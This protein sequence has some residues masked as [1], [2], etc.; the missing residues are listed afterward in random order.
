MAW[1]PEVLVFFLAITPVVGCSVAPPEKPDDVCEIFDER[2]KWYRQALAA[3]K[4]WDMPVAVGLA[5][6]H[7]ESSY[8]SD[9][10]PP[11][12]RFLWVFPGRRPSSAYGYAQATDAAWKDYQAATGAWLVERDN[13]GDALDFIGWYNY[14]SSRHLGIAKNDAY[15]LYLAYYAGV[16]GYASGKWKRNERIKGY[17]RKVSN[18]ANQY[19]RQ[20][21]RCEHRLDK[22]WWP[23]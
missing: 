6:V 17:A 20:L 7:R 2:P 5:F 4:D 9:A 22:G 12:G 3:Q 16:S 15:H 11:R 1:K 21:D 19:Q 23:F 8:Q 10:K 14:R 13:F 18:R